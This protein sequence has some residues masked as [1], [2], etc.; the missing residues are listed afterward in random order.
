VWS[1][2]LKV[3]VA[4][5]AAGLIG[6]GAF[7]WIVFQEDGPGVQRVPWSLTAAPSGASLDAV[8]TFGGSSCSRFDHWS[9]AETDATVTIKAYAWFS[10]AGD[11]TADDVHD[12]RTFQLVRPL[13]SRHLR[14]CAPE[15]NDA[16]CRLKDQPA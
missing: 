7:A 6:M 4:L 1:T 11:C 14:G 8:A 15:N 10:G 2:S 13:G 12:A 16:D 3:A 5:V 9:V